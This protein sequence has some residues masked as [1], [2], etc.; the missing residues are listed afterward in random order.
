[1]KRVLSLLVLVVL[2]VVVGVVAYQFIVPRTEPLTPRPPGTDGSARWAYNAAYATA[3]SELASDA[4]VVAITGEG[5][6]PDGRLAAN[7]GR[8]MLDFSSFSASDRVRIT[9][10]HLGQ[11]SVGEHSSPGVIHA[12]GSPPGNFTDSIAIFNSTTGHGAPGTRTVFD[13]VVCA[14]DEIAGSHVWTI[15]F[16]VDSVTETHK[17][18]ADGVWLELR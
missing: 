1:M 9:V 13:P 5:V 7:R 6:M 18:R 10:N 3:Q 12:L 16:K 14:F 8:W 4:V 11:V 17:V 15:I 2:I